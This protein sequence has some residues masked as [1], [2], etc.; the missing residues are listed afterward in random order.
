MKRLCKCESS[1]LEYTDKPVNAAEQ[2]HS[3][4]MYLLE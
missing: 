3:V 2:D 4:W 1:E